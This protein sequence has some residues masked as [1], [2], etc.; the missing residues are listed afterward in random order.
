MELDEYKSLAL[1]F[2]QKTL[3]AA[4]DFWCNMLHLH[5]QDVHFELVSELPF[6]IVNW[7][8]RETYPSFTE[9]RKLFKG[10]VCGGMRQGTLVYRDAAEVRKEAVDAIQQTEGRNF[11]LGTG[12]VVPIIASYGNLMAARKS[13]E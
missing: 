3:E 5:G 2:D 6:Q 7:H 12:C 11:L 4:E 1:P 13:V 10:V 9:A 8:D